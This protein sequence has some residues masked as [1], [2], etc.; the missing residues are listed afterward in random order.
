MSD[1]R[2]LRLSA[3]GFLVLLIAASASFGE[4]M[5]A[6]GDP[7]HVFEDYYSK[8]ANHRQDVAGAYL[9]TLTGIAFL[10]FSVRLTAL[11]SW[12]QQRQIMGR[13][14]NAASNP[15]QQLMAK[16]V[17]QTITLHRKMLMISSLEPRS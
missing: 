13:N 17:P 10:I 4:L 7:D 5:G 11:L 8:S 1:V 2:V 15:Q 6:F 16:I 3:V 14:T 9:L 12:Y